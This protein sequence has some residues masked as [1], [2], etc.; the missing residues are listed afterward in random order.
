[1]HYNGKSMKDV[2]AALIARDEK[3]LIAKRKKGSH[4]EFKWEFPG[5]KVE[6][7][8]T[9]K[10]CLERELWEEFGI[11]TKTGKFIVSSVFDYKNIKINLMAY[12]SKYISGEFILHAHEEIK[13]VLPRQ[14]K[15]FDF[16]EADLPI[17]DK[18]L[19]NI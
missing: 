6:R 2:T 17:I 11:N 19:E 13:W 3:V 5:G 15:N 16:A 12:H 18:L 1:M 7:G 9:P 14:M 8:E 10:K 4:L